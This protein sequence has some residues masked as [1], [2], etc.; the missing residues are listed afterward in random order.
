MPLA[1]ASISFQSR[2][3]SDRL[4]DLLRCTVAARCGNENVYCLA[5]LQLLIKGDGGA[6]SSAPVGSHVV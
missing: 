2:C 3:P 1:H 6:D 4:G 5:P